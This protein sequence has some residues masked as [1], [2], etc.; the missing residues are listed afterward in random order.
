MSDFQVGELAKRTSSG[1][2]YTVGKTYRVKEGPV[3]VD[4]DGQKRPFYRCDYE[5]LGGTMSR[6]QEYTDRI[7]ALENGWDK[8]ADDLLGEIRG[9]SGNDECVLAI[10]N[11]TIYVY[12]K[13]QFTL[14]KNTNFKTYF[15]YTSQCEKMSAFR[16]ALLWLLGHSNIKKN[17]KQ[18]KIDCLQRQIDLMQE[19]LKELK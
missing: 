13:W 16:E 11:N 7:N 18:E 10:D 4:N 14:E 12:S 9:E 3:V 6:Y 17:E 15:R 8:D 2:G 1:E 19:E 5:K